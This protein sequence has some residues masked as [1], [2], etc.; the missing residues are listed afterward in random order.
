M[1]QFGNKTLLSAAVI[2]AMA[3]ATTSA[4]AA[5]FAPFTVNE[6]SVTGT[7]ASTFVAGKVTGN[8][9]ENVTLKADG[10]FTTQLLFNAGT[11]G[12]INGTTITDSFLTSAAAPG[13]APTNYALYGILAGSGTF[14]T[15]G[16]GTTFTFTPGGSLTLAIDPKN[17]TTFNTSATPGALGNLAINSGNGDDFV[18][19]T[20]AVVGGDGT[21]S[22][23]CTPTA[24]IN[25]GSFGANTSLSLT[26][27]G[28]KFFTAP[29]PFYNLALTSGQFDNINVTTFGTAQRTTGSLDATFA[30]ATSV[31]E[32][33]SIALF[34]IG[35]LGLGAGMRRRKQVS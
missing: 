22:S 24:T 28:S 7:P 5:V 13:A 34:G 14:V 1:K 4:N 35:L 20:G 18:I 30:G 9:I 33:E 32:P 2:A 17:N 10:T 31:P 26:A 11:F 15:T 25:C 16:A 8:Y 19:G 27:A 21:L 12:D 6:G 29:V 3:F 23:S